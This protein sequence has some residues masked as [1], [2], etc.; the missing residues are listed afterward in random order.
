MA[1]FV[2]LIPLYKSQVPAFGPIIVRL[3]FSLACLGCISD[4]IMELFLYFKRLYRRKISL[5]FRLCTLKRLK[6]A[7]GGSYRV[8]K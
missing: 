4:V 6:V 1:Q 3:L 2:Y 7:F 8:S 5:S